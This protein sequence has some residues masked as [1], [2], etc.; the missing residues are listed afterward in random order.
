MNG[1]LETYDMML[2][3]TLGR[4]PVKI[5]ATE[6][7]PQDR[8]AMKIV[9]SPIGAAL[10]SNRKRG[11]N[12]VNQLIDSVVGPQMPLTA[13][14]NI[15]GLPAM[16]VPLFWTDEGLPIGVQFVGRFCD[17]ATLFRLA[18]QLEKSRSWFDKKPPVC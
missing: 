9:N 3:P 18:S 13:V 14:A 15:T 12:I 2:T 17:E 1:L 11:R 10:F 16:S 8:I 5:G 6:P 7:G 4:P